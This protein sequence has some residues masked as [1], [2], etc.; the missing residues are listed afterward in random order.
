MHN[1]AWRAFHKFRGLE[2]DTKSTGV[3]YG[4]MRDILTLTE[5]HCT[6]HVAFCFDSQTS[7]REEMFPEYK[8][9]RRQ[10]VWSDDEQAQ[11]LA[12]RKQI[13]LLRNKILPRLG[14][15]NVFHADGFEGDDMIA[16]V[17]GRVRHDEEAVVVSSDKDLYQ[18]L[19]HNVYIWHPVDKTSVSVDSFRNRYGIHPYQ[20]AKVKALV[21]CKSDGVPG[22]K[23]V[24]EKYAVAYLKGNLPE[25]SKPFKLIENNLD[26]MAHNLKL[27]KLP[28]KGCPRVKLDRSD[29]INPLVW[30]RVV[31]EFGLKSLAGKVPSR[32]S[33]FGL[34]PDRLNKK[35]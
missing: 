25:T 28:L 16:A 19:R 18:L 14:Y 30:R 15:R 24:G 2:F 35:E 26:V 1:L 8:Q 20:W 6:R 33:G 11:F 5:L 3:I 32:V 23:G 27:V 4:V 12:M 13:I 7:R 10:K 17:C 29:K 31:E 34:R 21:G 22:I 9:E